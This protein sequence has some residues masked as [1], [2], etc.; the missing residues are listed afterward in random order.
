MEQID[1]RQ[2]QIAG[3]LAVQKDGAVGVFQATKVGANMLTGVFGTTGEADLDAATKKFREIN[4]TISQMRSHPMQI[5]AKG[6]DDLMEKVAR[7][8]AEHALVAGPEHGFHGREP[9]EPEGDVRLRGADAGHPAEV[10]QSAVSKSSSPI[11]E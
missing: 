4:E 5:D 8:E 3:N 9:Q 1:R 7:A 6:M 2:R 10:P 11:R